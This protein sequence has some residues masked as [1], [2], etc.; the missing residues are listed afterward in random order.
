M[1]ADE[2]ANKKG[3]LYSGCL[4]EFKIATKGQS[5]HH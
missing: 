2:K 5:L 1:R 4:G 3:A